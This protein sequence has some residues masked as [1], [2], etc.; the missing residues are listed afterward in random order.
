ML[1]EFSLTPLL[2]RSDLLLLHVVWSSAPVRGSGHT[3]LPAR[4]PS[5]LSLNLKLSPG[6]TDAGRVRRHRELWW[7]VKDA[8]GIERAGARAAGQPLSAPDALSRRM[9]QPRTCAVLG[10]GGRLCTAFLTA[11]GSLPV[12]GHPVSSMTPGL[13]AWPPS[14]SRKNSTASPATGGALPPPGRVGALAF[15]KALPARSFC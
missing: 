14:S 7:L 1:P 3:A 13:R 5:A 9:F 12:Q 4:S 11:C 2:P 6:G 10:G 8:P 15:A